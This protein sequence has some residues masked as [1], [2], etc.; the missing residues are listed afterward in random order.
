MLN[1][2]RWIIRHFFN[3]QFGFFLLA[4]GLAAVLHWLARWGLSGI[5]PFSIAVVL[6]YVVGMGS[7]FILNRAFVFPNS[8]RSVTMQARDFILVNLAFF[9][10][11]WGASLLFARLLHPLTEDVALTEGLAHGGAIL[12]PIFGSFLLHKFV[13]FATHRRPKDVAQ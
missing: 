8:S 5:L 1:R 9:P 11:V 10:V 12:L 6:A 3:P 4:G 2:A 7:A 13:T